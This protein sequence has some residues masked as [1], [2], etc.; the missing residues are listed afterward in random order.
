MVNAGQRRVQLVVEPTTLEIFDPFG[1]VFLASWGLAG[2]AE[3]L[4]T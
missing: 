4:S 3:D 1:D 2:W